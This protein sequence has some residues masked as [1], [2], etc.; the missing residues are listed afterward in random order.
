[1]TKFSTQVW[2]IYYPAIMWYCWRFHILD[3]A[4]ISVITGQ[5]FT[6]V[7]HVM[8]SDQDP[9]Q[10]QGPQLSVPGVFHSS[11]VQATPLLRKTASVPPLDGRTLVH[12]PVEWFSTHLPSHVSKGVHLP[13]PQMSLSPIIEKSSPKFPKYSDFLCHCWAPEWNVGEVCLTTPD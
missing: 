4:P 2:P 12:L 9:L 3:L 1:M 5:R 10:P 6:R 13:F 7:V 8:G 11:I